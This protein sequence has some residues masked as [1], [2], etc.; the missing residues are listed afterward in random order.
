[1]TFQTLQQLSGLPWLPTGRPWE[2]APLQPRISR[3][4]IPKDRCSF[5]ESQQCWSKCTDVSANRSLVIRCIE[6]DDLGRVFNLCN[7]LIS[8]SG[9]VS[10]LFLLVLTWLFS[11]FGT[12]LFGEVTTLVTPL[13]LFETWFQCGFS[14]VPFCFC[15]EFGWGIFGSSHL[16]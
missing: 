12:T 9:L 4:S 1:M 11:V 5:Q 6:T 2:E 14:Y 15:H 16:V 8:W 3:C 10:F 7:F 13:V